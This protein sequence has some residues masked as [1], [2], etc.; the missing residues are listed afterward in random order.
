MY[1]EHTKSKQKKRDGKFWARQRNGERCFSSCQEY[2]AKKK[3]WVPMR[4]QTS[5]LRIPQSNALPLSHRDC[6]DEVYYKVHMTHILHTAG[7][8]NVNSII[9]VNRIRKMVSFSSGRIRIFFLC[10]TLMTTSFS[11]LKV[12]LPVLVILL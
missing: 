5:D 2:G 6:G 7:I 12:L 1:W 9:F 8:R 10:P 4:N 3:F 11:I